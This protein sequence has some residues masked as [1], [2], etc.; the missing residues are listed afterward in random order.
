M[1]THSIYKQQWAAEVSVMLGCPSDSVC[2]EARN[3][4]PGAPSPALRIK[5]TQRFFFL[6]T[7]PDM[8]VSD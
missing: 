5:Q 1:N 6:Q 3:H 7:F 4:T 8:M 2:R